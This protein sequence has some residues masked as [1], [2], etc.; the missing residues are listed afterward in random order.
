[1][2][3]QS[4]ARISNPG[5]YDT[6]FLL[7]RSL[8]RAVSDLAPRCTA[9]GGKAVD[10]GCGSMPYRS[11]FADVGMTY[12]G[13][14]FDAG[15]VTIGPDGRLPIDAASAD[16][17]TS[18]QVLEHVRDL[19]TYFAEIR[20]VLRPGGWLM[21]S[22]HGTWLYHPHPE[23]HRRWTRTGLEAELHA[24]GFGV[25]HTVPVLG[26]LAWTTV[27]RSTGM[28]FFLRR[29]PV[30]GAPLAGGIA[31]FMNL[32]AALEDRITPESVR[33]DNA[34]VYVTLSRVLP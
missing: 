24:H 21:L 15:D 3:R 25:E 8:M 6:D 33:R 7:L 23:D 26:P 20:R 13:A 22:T 5:F 18:F 1:M 12:V 32:R 16:L 10:Y 4:A 27:L 34:C 17:V 30:I 31:A 2:D 28:A 9:V 29:V 14:D 19:G 11:I